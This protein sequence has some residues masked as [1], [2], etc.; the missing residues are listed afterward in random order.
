MACA[1]EFCQALDGEMDL[2]WYGWSL[3]WTLSLEERPELGGQVK[4]YRKMHLHCCL[5]LRKEM[6]NEE[7]DY[8]AELM[9]VLE[10]ETARMEGLVMS[11]VCKPLPDLGQS[12]INRSGGDQPSP[13]GES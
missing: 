13:Q 4:E 12:S 1:V 8:K 11:R 6:K 7:L 9:A 2:Q 5:K 10:A 3:G